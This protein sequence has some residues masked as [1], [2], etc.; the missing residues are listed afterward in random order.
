MSS[1]SRMCFLR[2]DKRW[3]GER[4]PAFP[5]SRLICLLPFFLPF[6]ILFLPS[7]LLRFE[8]PSP[9]FSR[10]LTHPPPH[11]SCS[12]LTAVHCCLI[13]GG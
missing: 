3:A 9:H 10:P 13:I 5:N 4:F 12:L 8:D 11:R 6:P 2:A 1:T 7:T